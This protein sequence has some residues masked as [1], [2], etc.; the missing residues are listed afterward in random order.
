MRRALL[1]AVAT[2]LAAGS[3]AAQGPPA[4]T[5]Q[6][7]LFQNEGAMRRQLARM[8]AAA[9]LDQAGQCRAWREHVA[10]M[11]GARAIFARCQTGHLRAE[12]VGQMEASIADF[13]ALLA[14][15]CRG[16]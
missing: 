7:D 10:F 15:R 6:R 2:L 1:A 14:S 12:N 16:R 8:E 5:C 13:R 11:Q 4:A 9:R 3:A